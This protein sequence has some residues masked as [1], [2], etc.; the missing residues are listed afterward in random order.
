MPM[1]TAKTNVGGAVEPVREAIPAGWYHSLIIGVKMGVTRSAKINPP[2]TTISI[3]YQIV[4]KDAASLAPGEV[5]TTYGGKSVYQDYI[6]EEITNNAQWTAGE[7]F[8]VQQLLLATKIPHE[9]SEGGQATFNTDH[10]VNKGVKIFVSSR[11]GTAKPG[12]D[13]KAPIPTF[14]NVER[15]DTIEQIDDKDLV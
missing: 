5:D 3:E 2:L 10:L 15:V 9:L 7:A 11:P 4:K 8:R 13:P 1:V 6:L 14:N 12:A